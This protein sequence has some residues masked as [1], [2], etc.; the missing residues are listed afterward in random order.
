MKRKIITLMLCLC[1]VLPFGARV[2]AF[3]FPQEF[4]APNDAFIQAVEADDKQGII[5]YGKQLI[6]ILAPLE[7]ATEKQNALIDRYNKVAKAYEAIGDYETSG[8]YYKLLYDYTSQFGDTYYDYIMGAKA[9]YLQYTKRIYLYT[10]NG[11]AIYYG[12]KN[13]P[14]NGV[15]F[16]VC[17]DSETRKSI[18]GDESLILTYQ[19]IC[20]PLTSYNKDA[21]SDALYHND[22][23]EFALNCPHESTCIS[24]IRNLEANLQEISDLFNVYPDV[25]IFLRFAAEFDVWTDLAEPEDYKAAFRFVSDFFEKRSP[26]VAMVWSPNQVSNYYVKIDD[27]YPGDEYVDWV[28]ISLYSMPYFQGDKNA[29]RDNEVFFKTGDSA[30]PVLAVEDII[31]KYGDRK[32]IMISESGV[33]HSLLETGENTTD[34]ALKKLRRELLY[35]P[36]VYPQIKAIAYFDV[37]GT[38][39]NEKYDFRLSS[40]KKLQEEYIKLTNGERFIKSDANTEASISYEKVTENTGLN[41]KF[42]VSCYAHKFG[43]EVSEVSY[44]ICGEFVAKSTVAPYTV[45]IDTAAYLGGH[46]LEATVK[47][48]DGTTEQTKVSVT[49]NG[50]K[51]DITV[52]VAGKNIAF[53]QPPVIVSGRT[54]VP[55]R[56]I[57]EALGASVAWDDA[58]KTATGLKGDKEVK[59]TIGADSMYVN[60]MAVAL[61]APAM[62]M[63]G[64]TMVPARA[65]AEGLGCTVG[66]DKKTT[67]VTID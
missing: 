11:D 41:G 37:T 54:M 35:L 66:W 56:A 25:K 34:F 29:G 40:N 7:D 63:S 5:N 30:D 49:L 21:L 14:K 38:S 58:T 61:D 39:K 6:D 57:F 16:G 36:M 22:A 8:Y 65:I 32:P 67:T 51:N 62:V 4:W 53:D 45:E 20:E 15:L 42:P 44:Y 19:E 47:F 13:E 2:S 18:E 26:N 23:I 1:T 60:G 31:K 59:I 9:K 17:V 64:R 50:E 46:S 55:M 33:G 27:Y 10:D 24:N 12:A 28:G 3:S 43:K 52:K 48:T